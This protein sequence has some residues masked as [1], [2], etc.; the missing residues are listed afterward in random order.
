M[1]EAKQEGKESAMRMRYMQQVGE[2]W[3]VMNYLSKF[4]INLSEV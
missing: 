4:K 1:M 2:S 3:D